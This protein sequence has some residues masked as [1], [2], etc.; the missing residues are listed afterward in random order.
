[1]AVGG[2]ACGGG[3]DWESTSRVNRTPAQRAASKTYEKPVSTG[4]DPCDTPI[5]TPAPS[6]AC[7]IADIACGQSVSGSTSK[8]G[9]SRF[10]DAFYLAQYCSP[11]RHRYD[12]AA[13]VAYRLKVPANTR[14]D[15]A[16]VSDC[17]D[18]DLATA[19]WSGTGCPDEAHSAKPCEMTAERGGGSVVITTVN[20]PETHLVIVDGKKGAEGNFTVSV[21][22]G[23]YR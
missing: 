3:V 10:G 1:V 11:E 4:P 14:A 16:L 6:Q 22:C 12:D 15:V 20:R 8:G 21:T 19:L 17:V 5:E 2:L 9:R 7:Y 18:L 23:P 13:E